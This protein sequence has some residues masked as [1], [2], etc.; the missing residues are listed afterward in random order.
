M[1]NHVPEFMKDATNVYR[2]RDFIVRQ[3]IGIQ[4]DGVENNVVFSRDTYYRRTKK[5]DAEYELVYCSRR[6]VNGERLPTTM[7]SREY[8][9]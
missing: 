1:E 4:Y 9:N 8:I 5:R 7:Y 2:T 3:V 6:N